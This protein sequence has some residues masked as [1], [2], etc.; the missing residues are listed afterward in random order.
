MI[1][2]LTLGEVTFQNTEI[3]SEINFGGSQSISVKQLVGGQRIIDAMGRSDDDITWSGLFFGPTALFRAQFLDGMRV[4]GAQLRLTW[5]RF[6]YIVVIKEFRASFQRYYQI[7]YQITVTVIQDLNQPLDFLLPVGYNDVIQSAIVEA[8]D[9]ATVLGSGRVLESLELLSNALNN[10]PSMTMATAQQIYN[11][12]VL[13]ANCVAVTRSEIEIQTEKTK[14]IINEYG[15]YTVITDPN[16]E[17]VSESMLQVAE[18]YR[19]EAILVNM[20]TNILLIQQGAQGKIVTVQNANLF[21]LAAQYY[22]DA[23]LWNTIATAN[24]LYDPFV[25]TGVISSVIVNIGGSDYPDNPPIIISGDAVFPANLKAIVVDG[26]VVGIRIITGGLYNSPP[27]ISITGGSVL[28]DVS[29]ICSRTITIPANVTN[30]TG[31]VYTT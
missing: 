25:T 4:Q 13:V 10:I 9:I 21:Q 3:P 19:V 7:P 23:T 12:L 22:G 20:Q 15:P 14:T 8:I 26:G 29:A 30:N 2:F 6:N 11:V 18:L 27:V 16:P 31:G 1:D 17:V 28:A 24:G 5:S